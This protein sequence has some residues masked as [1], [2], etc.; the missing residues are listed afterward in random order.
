[1][2]SITKYRQTAETLRR[3]I[4]RAYGT[5]LV[6][7]GDDFAS[8]LGHGWFNV[9]YL[10]RLADGREV[11][12][13]IAPPPG[14]EVMTYELDMLAG[15]VAVMRLLELRTSVP[16]PHLDHY[17]PSCELI[18]APWFVMTQVPGVNFGE[19]SDDWPV[20][21]SQAVW[22]QIGAANRE[23]NSLVGT[24]FGRFGVAGVASWRE[25]FTGILDDVLRD[26]ERREVD[27]GWSYDEVRAAIA[28]HEACLDAVTEPRFCEWDLW[29]SN[30]MVDDDRITGIIDHERAF[31]G[32]PI[33]EA[34]FVAASGTVQWGSPS[35]YLAGYGRGPLTADELDRR[36]LYNLHLFLIMVIETVY[37][38]HTTTDQLD[39]A[40]PALDAAMADL[41][42]VRAQ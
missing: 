17:D 42:H 39:M 35:A 18:A 25:A 40:R 30:V 14:V 6:P 3:M 15:E 7:V 13:K 16:V 27:L 37:R 24:G 12:M 31:W 33:M 34:G 4:E 5:G 8:E 28:Q 10:L 23:L 21:R 9:A 2:E 11:V 32:D 19:V 29:G 41:G 38:G 22:R 36:R 1:M 20:E 26:G